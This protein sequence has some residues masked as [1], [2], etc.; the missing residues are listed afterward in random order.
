[1][2]SCV[3]SLQMTCAWITLPPNLFHRLSKTRI[4]GANSGPTDD[5]QAGV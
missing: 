2:P 1:M 3:P 4:A 5:L